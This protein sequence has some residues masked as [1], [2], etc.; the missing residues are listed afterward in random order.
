MPTG[1]VASDEFR[2]HD[3]GKGHPESPERMGAI[4]RAI[5]APVLRSRIEELAPPAADK[6]HIL[7]VHW[8]RLYDEVMATRD[9]DQTYLDSDTVASRDT[10]ETA[11]LAVGSVLTGIERVVE[12]RLTN[13]FAFPRPPGHHAKP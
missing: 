10:A 13:V 8:E 5:E 3:P 1:V 6:E 12:G 4:R 11:H 7:L 9:R 2:K